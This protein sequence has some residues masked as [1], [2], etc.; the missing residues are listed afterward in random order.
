MS[1][2]ANVI[3]KPPAAISSYLQYH[4]GMRR[5]KWLTREI[6]LPN[7]PKQSLT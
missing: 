3:E 2:I 1:N 5:R 7:Q 4:G 6:N